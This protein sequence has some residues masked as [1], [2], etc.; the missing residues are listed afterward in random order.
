MTTRGTID[1][2]AASAGSGKTWRIVTEVVDAIVQGTVRPEA[3]VATTFSRRAATALRDALRQ[4]LL[5]AGRTDD[6]LRLEGAR[7][8]TVHALCGTFLQQFALDLGRS[9]DLRVLDEPDSDA[10]LRESL[11]TVVTP[12]ELDRFEHLRTRLLGFDGLRDAARLVTA[13]RAN[14]VA[15]E[16]FAA[17]AEESIASLDG[18]LGPV[19]DDALSLT[20]ALDGALQPLVAHRH[21]SPI[22]SEV[23]A[24]RDAGRAL[25]WALWLKLT[26]LDLGASLEAFLPPLRVAA[27]AHLRHPQLRDDLRA[28]I[29]SVYLLAARATPHFAD[30]RRLHRVVDFL[31]QEDLCLTLL[32][33]PE[34]RQALAGAFDLVVV[35]EFQDTSP[36]Q[37]ALF[38]ELAALCP[39]SLWVGDAKQSIYAFRGADPDL[40][41]RA[42]NAVLG[43]RPPET[44]HLSWRSRPPLVDLT[45]GL[46]APPFAAHGTP[47]AQV[48]L[49]PA[50]PVDD[51][52]LGP[53]LERWFLPQSSLADGPMGIARGIRALLADEKVRVRD[54][55]TKALRRPGPQDIAVLAH[56]NERCRAIADA[57]AG[58]GVPSDVARA[59]LLGTPEVRLVL[60]AVK[61]L[62]DPNDRLAQAELVRL[63]ADSPTDDA[64][65]LGVLD[66]GPALHEHP[67][68][69]ALRALSLDPV[70]R[71]LL[72]L[73]DT[74]FDTLDVY[75][76][77]A[78]WGDV[79]QRHA[80]LDALRALAVRW[81]DQRAAE[82]RAVSVA[83]WLRWLK[84]L[85]AQSND[86]QGRRAGAAIAV[87]T[88][89]ASKGLEWP[90][91]VLTD[92]ET[93]RDPRVL[94]VRA[95]S[96][97]EAF[98]LDN[99]LAGRHL[100]YWPSPY[101]GDDAGTFPDL[102]L[103]HDG[104]T[105]ALRDA[106]SREA[107]RLLYVA[108]TRARDRLVLAARTGKLVAG[109]LALLQHNGRPL[110]QDA[111]LDHQVQ[112]LQ[113]T[114][115]IV[116]RTLAAKPSPAPLPE[117]PYHV[118]PPSDAPAARAPRWVSP[119][120]LVATGVALRTVS[121]GPA[122]GLA[123]PVDPRLMG[124]V[125]H[126]WFA[127][128]TSQS[129]PPP[130]EE[131][132]ALLD[133]AGLRHALEPTALGVMAESLRAW[134]RR[135]APDAELL[136][137]WPVWERRPDGT[138]LRGVADLVLADERGLVVIDH[139]SHH[140]HDAEAQAA[141]HYGQLAAYGAA[142]AAAVGRPLRGQW[143][144]LPLAG[145]M[146]EI[147][148]PGSVAAPPD[149]VDAPTDGA[150]EVSG[151]STDYHAKYWA[152]SIALERPQDSVAGLSRSLGNARVDLNPHQIEAALFALR[153]P[154]SKGV[155][156]ADEV[157]LGKTIEAGIVLSQK[158]AE[159]RRKILLIAPATLRKQWQNELAGK[160]FLPSRIV[161]AKTLK[162]AQ[163]KGES[164]PFRQGDAVVIVSYEFAYLRAAD[165]KSVEWDL[166]VIDE[167][168]RLRSIYKQ[169]KKAKAIVDAIH[170]KHKVLLTAT[171]LQNTLLELFGLVSVL[172]D[173]LFG[174]Q[175]AFAAQ[176]MRHDD[177]EERN[178]TL[179]DRIR[180]VCHRTLRRQVMQ[181]IKFTERHPL[182]L[183]FV[184]SDKEVELYNQV[185]DYLQREVLVALPKS[186]RKLITMI[187]RKLLASSSAAIEATLGKFIA[188]LQKAQGAL[189]PDDVTT[190]LA[191]NYEGVS[192][193]AEDWSEEDEAPTTA[194]AFGK[195]DPA[196]PSELS[197][198]QKYIALA[199]SIGEDAKTEQ[200]KKGLEQAFEGAVAKGAARKAVVFTE[201]VKTQE[202]LVEWLSKHG[203]EGRI[204]VMNG[205][206]TDQRSKAI[207]DAWKKRHKANWA[208]V[209]SGSRTADMKTAIVEEF[210]SDRVELLIA[211]ESAAEGVNLQFCSIV[212][213]YDLPWNP[214]RIEQRIGRCHR[215]GQKH[216][217]L[218]V[219]FRNLKNEADQRVFELLDQKFKLFS[220]VFG[221]SDDVLGTIE[222]GVD[223]E[224]AIADIYQTCRT[225]E[226]IKQAFD[227]LQKQVGGEIQSAMSNTRQKVLENLDEEVQE[228]LQVHRDKAA[229][230]LQAQERCLLAVC[231]HE[232]R[233]EAEFDPEEPRFTLVKPE[234]DRTHR[235]FHLKWPRADERGDEFLRVQHPFAEGLLKAC[236]E[237]TT[238]VR[239]LCFAYGSHASALEPMRTRKGWLRVVRYTTNAL[240]REE[241]ALLLTAVTDDGTVLSRELTEKLF[242]LEAKVAGDAAGAGEVPAALRGEIEKQQAATRGN[243]DSRNQTYFTEEE[244][245]LNARVEDIRAGLEGEIKQLDKELTSLKKQSKLAKQL[246]EKI[247]AQK[248]LKAL[249]EKRDAKLQTLY[250]ELAKH[251][252]DQDEY[253]KALEGQLQ[254]K[255]ERLD[256][257]F[258][259][260]WSLA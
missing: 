62:R 99:P 13:A 126:A 2:V 230:S 113:R 44:L 149:E 131:A 157:G 5:D 238:P 168:H 7:I 42:A 181:Y 127:A 106:E 210:Q 209:S 178:V 195:D 96:S 26:N 139:K 11:E 172:D 89:H 260:R 114:W 50:H 112:W 148:P 203:Y 79:D 241:N 165:V 189:V 190:D 177:E 179:K 90:V 76:R 116:S 71:G 31:D 98:S 232:L 258:T 187:L 24:L 3:V 34:V 41:T 47:A 204:A 226:E 51:V 140:G 240:G 118:A 246:E 60:A 225:T 18:L 28:A 49:K 247:E 84:M 29:E 205:T 231:R 67:T 233:G 119:S 211:T 201:S 255:D 14:H 68:V 207:Y 134:I 170:N 32:Q 138:M 52:A 169:S 4:R 223:I 217:V 16:T 19:A 97:D 227:E 108:W 1:F 142:L 93:T 12:A 234:E 242:A 151:M 69:S 101:A 198:L 206:N 229:Q 183:D 256:E 55:A 43:D 176:Y 167:A 21:A 73:V 191:E 174:S 194:S 156:L 153:S 8:G 125:L 228:K 208:G 25:P 150:T 70:V 104:T 58:E 48:V 245:K 145:K 154:F 193:V 202:Y 61:L 124:T 39:R 53:A 105:R 259:V 56:T 115:P 65:L 218:V 107:L 45:S 122:F 244:E 237:R 100:R 162:D 27:A 220:G 83:G 180:H 141:T 164:S 143:I 74:A 22:L 155:L 188:R 82:D 87:L 250:V 121:I 78:R 37:L 129:E 133:A 30:L 186:Q 159:R 64:W 147:A 236:I 196:L 110:L 103:R 254:Q 152:H 243:I 72:T 35:D 185:S 36:L 6:A 88:W 33:R 257:V 75:P 171:P 144:H 135:T 102:A 192:D 199:A 94:G 221:A 213:N 46:F 15:P 111:R 40:V 222:N 212:V 66:A 251:R 77:V 163:K 197:D 215:Y 38:V 239:E 54:P 173:Q 80:N 253:I 92:L 214:Q 146:V 10:L 166:V 235:S 109:P 9:P 123:G 63:D 160:F 136:P 59:G 224:R 20:N 252:Q 161:E 91:V 200:L 57:L 95:F 182:T 128:V 175:E 137:E 184:P 132:T 17:L 249:N 216:D 248:K 117:A 158:W 23:F 85:A 81:I 219:N 120:S 86:A 130:W